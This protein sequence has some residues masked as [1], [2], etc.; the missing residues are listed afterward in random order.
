MSIIG[1]RVGPI[2]GSS[3]EEFAKT[4][5]EF[6]HVEICNAI[7]DLH[8]SIS[9]LRDFRDRIVGDEGQCAGENLD[10]LTPS[11]ARVLEELPNDIRSKAGQINELIGE[12]ES[13]L[14]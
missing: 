8:R 12:I 3:L 7:Q 1:Q 13:L 4:T 5:S 2:S 11:L 6:K 9:N 10:E 14:F